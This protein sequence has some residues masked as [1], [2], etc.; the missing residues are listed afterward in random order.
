M[1]L[2]LND[3]VMFA[4]EEKLREYYSDIK[5]DNTT[6]DYW[7]N[8]YRPFFGKVLVIIDT[9]PIIASH[10]SEWIYDISREELIFISRGD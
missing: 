3:K 4:S 2:R 8:E 7:I 10:G 6:A 5:L 9:F 1:N